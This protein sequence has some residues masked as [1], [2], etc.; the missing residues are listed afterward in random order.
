MRCKNLKCFE[1]F[2]LLFLIFKNDA[3]RLNILLFLGGKPLFLDE[4]EFSYQVIFSSSEKIE[5][6]LKKYKIWFTNRF[7]I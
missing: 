4:P 5:K 3:Q 1:L 6:I 7:L 2:M